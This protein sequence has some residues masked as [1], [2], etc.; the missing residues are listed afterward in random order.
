[1][2]ILHVAA[3]SRTFIRFRLP[4]LLSQKKAGHQVE[5][6]C[7]PDAPYAA[8][9]KE[10]GI[11]IRNVRMPDTSN[12]KW[13]EIIRAIGDLRRIL[14]EDQYNILHAH[15]PMGGLVGL[16]AGKFDANLKLLYTT[17]GL[18]S[19]DG[20]SKT[21]KWITQFFEKRIFSLAD[22]I[23]SVNREDIETM[24]REGLADIR[25]VCFVGPKGG[26]GIDADKF[27]PFL[28][29]T[30]IN[31]EREKL[32]IPLTKGSILVGAVGRIVWEKGY[33][34]LIE[35]FRLITEKHPNHSIKCI[36]IGTGPNQSDLKEL[37]ESYK[38]KNIV[39]LLGRKSNVPDFLRVLDIFV[40]ASYREGMPTVVLEAMASALPVVATNIRGSREAITNN[41]N[42]LLINVKAPNELADKLVMLANNEDQR[43]QLA[44]MAREEIENN[45]AADVL[46]PRHIEFLNENFLRK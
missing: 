34:E 35:A 33:R 30:N 5:V 42:G 44:K 38:L 25:K 36:I 10:C 46:L 18:K 24:E 31:E 39:F 4:I 20:M 37:I 7:R 12:F 45:Y 41:E 16:I 23:F 43:K 26:C 32:E 40:L 29:P 11:P 3:S 27:T 28:K 22:A 13:T 2:K 17:G 19:H 21:K 1:M 9:I 6:A 15:Q 14:K 8:S